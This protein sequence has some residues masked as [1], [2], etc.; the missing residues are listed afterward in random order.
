MN[1]KLFAGGRG[2][3]ST[4]GPRAAS[5]G[6]AAQQRCP[7]EVLLPVCARESE[8]MCERDREYVRERARVCARESE[9]DEI[10]S[11]PTY[12]LQVYLAHKKPPPPLGPP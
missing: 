4:D 3:A 1:N 2:G 12:T 8:S 7:Q 11:S 9:R 6:G 5:G 10:H